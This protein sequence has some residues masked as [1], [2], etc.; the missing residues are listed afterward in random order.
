MRRLTHDVKV[1]QLAGLKA[2]RDNLAASLEDITT[3]A[4]SRAP[5]ARSTSSGTPVR[6][7]SSIR[8]QREPDMVD[9][10]RAQRYDRRRIARS[11]GRVR[12]IGR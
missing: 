4:H 11:V 10:L 9:R 12:V 5:L 2:L 8:H 6:S 3:P 1:S 7:N